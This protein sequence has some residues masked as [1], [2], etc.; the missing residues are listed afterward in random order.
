MRD[1]FLPVYVYKESRA[2]NPGP[3]YNYCSGGRGAH[4]RNCEHRRKKQKGTEAPTSSSPW[5]I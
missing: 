1:I 2:G 5:L 4:Q 3:V